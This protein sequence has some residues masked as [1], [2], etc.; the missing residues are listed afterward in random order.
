MTVTGNIVSESVRDVCA[1][2]EE[3]RAAW[4]D[5]DAYARTFTEDADYVTFFGGRMVGRDGV[6]EGHR[7]LFEGVLK[8]SR[9]WAEIDDVVLLGPDTALVHSHGGV[10]KGKGERPG[11]RALSVQ[12]Y[13][14][15]RGAGGEWLIRTFQNTRSRPR[16]E[17]FSNWLAVKF[18]PKAG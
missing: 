7:G 12:T 17:A 18:A 6:A 14:M 9:L 5:T 13:L 8:G 1:A 2:F 3:H 16:V 10:I 11:K 15:V 4:G